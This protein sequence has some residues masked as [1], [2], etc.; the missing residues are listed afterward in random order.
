VSDFELR[1]GTNQDLALVYS[2]TAKSLRSSPLYRDL[3]P[4]QWREIVNGLIGRMTVEPWQLTVAYPTG[5]P[6]EVAG[7][8]LG[9]RAEKPVIGFAYVKEAYRQKGVARMLLESVTNGRPDFLTVLAQPRVL[10]WCRDRGMR[11]QLSPYLL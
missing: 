5:F 8:V 4:D 7:F 3:P 2:A 1:P 11:V 6:T 9:K 10:G